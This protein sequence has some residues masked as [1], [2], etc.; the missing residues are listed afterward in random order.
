MVMRRRRRRRVPNTMSARLLDRVMALLGG[1]LM[2]LSAQF[3]TLF[4][5]QLT[6]AVEGFTHLL[7]TLRRQALE[8]LPPLAQLLALLRGHGAPLLKSLLRAHALLRRHGE[9]ALT[10]LGQSLLA[11]RG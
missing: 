11:I 3:R 2:P 8:L 5:R 10:S 9:P 4:R 6:E 1:H 7:L